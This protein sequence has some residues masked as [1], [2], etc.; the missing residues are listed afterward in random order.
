MTK[1]NARSICIALAAA[2]LLAATPALAGSIEF[3]PPFVFSGGFTAPAGLA[4]D[5]A[6]GRIVVADTGA[7]RVKW[8]TIASLVAGSPA[9]TELGFVAD[10][11]LPEALNEPQAVAVDGAGNVYVVDT[12]AGEVQLYRWNPGTS[13]YAYDPAFAA[14]TRNAVAGLN[15]RFPRDIAIGPANSVYL[16]DSG[17]ER[18]LRA[19]GANDD[20][21]EV[22]RA[23]TSWAN[24]Y[25]IDV[26]ADG[27][28]YLAD[29]D[30]HRIVR[31]P[32]AGGPG[33][34]FGA[35]GIGNVL[36]RN[37]R[38]VAV[39]G[40]GRMFVAD[41]NNHRVEILTSTGEHYRTLG[42]AP[43]YGSIQKIETDLYGRVYV[44]DSHASRLIAFL[45]SD[46]VAPF[47][48]YLRDYA[49]DPGTQPSDDAFV[50]SS[51]DLLVR[52][53]P[54]VDVA[55]VTSGL[56]LIAFEQP[57]FEMNNYVY[58]AVRNRGKQAITGVT[59]KVYWAD[60]GTTLAFPGQWKTHGFY[61]RYVDSS[62]NDPG[63]SIFIPHIAP[64]QVISGEEVD[65]VTVVGPLVWR[66]PAPESVLAADGKVH[67][68]A[69]LIHLDDPTETESG[70]DQV[71]LN[72]NVGLRRTEVTRGPF[73]IGDQDTLVVRA[74]FDGVAGSANETTVT[75]R[76]T[77]LN[78]WLDRVSYGLTTLK[79]AFLGP[80][81]LDHGPAH[82]QSAS[83]N[84]LVEMTTEVLSKLLATQ[85]DLLDGPTADAADDID[86][87]ILVVNDPA[88][89]TDWATTGHWPYDLAGKTRHLSTS[90]QGP[91]N[92]TP[93]YAHGLSHQFGLRDLYIHDTIDA[94]DL[95]NVASRWDNM[96]KPFEGAH[97]L[98][99][100]KQYATWVTSL[101]G[102][103]FYIARPPSSSPRLGQPPT[104]VSFQ[105]VLE[106]GQF[107]AIAVG[108]TEGVTTFEEETHFYWVEARDPALGSDLVPQKGVI[109]YYAH[110]LIPQGEAPVI[111]RD[112]T[113]GTDT[114]DDAAVPAG[115]QLAPG[116]TGITVT[117]EAEIAGDGG[118]LV[119][120]DYEPPVEDLDVH[121]RAGDP[122]WTSPDIWI[123]NQRDGDGY[124]AYDAAEH[125]SAGPTDEGPIA[126]EE[127][128]VYARI[129][130][131]GPAPAFDVEVVFSLSEPYHTVAGEADF[132]FKSLRIL[133]II[134]PG[135]HRDVFFTWVPDEDD[136]PHTCAYVEIRRA[137][138]DTN[139]HNNAAQQNLTVQP[140][141]TSS[142]YTAV[143]FNFQVTNEKDDRPALVYFRADNI[144]EPWTKAFAQ[145]KKLLGPSEKFLGSLMLKPN[146]DAPVCSDVAVYVTGW[147]P[148][149]DTLVQLGGTTVNVALRNN[150]TLTT[151]A[152]VGACN[153]KML[154]GA[155][156]AN[157]TEIILD[158]TNGPIAMASTKPF[159]R[160]AT[161]SVTGCTIPPRPNET[162]YI[163]YT[164]PAGNPVWR[165]VTTDE[166]GCYEDFYV[167][168]EGG[169]WEATAFY[170][171]S[172]CS[173]PATGVVSVFVPLPQTGDQDN[174]GLPDADEPQGNDDD[175][176]FPNHLDPD[177]DNDG[178]LD[179]AEPTGDADQDG[180][181]NSVDPDSDNDGIPDGSDPDPYTPQP[182]GGGTWKAGAF[183]GWL[184]LDRDLPINDTAVIGLRG[185]LHLSG[186]WWL[187]AEA[188]FGWTDDDF[189]VSG[190][191]LQA[192]VHLLRELTTG[193][194]ATPFVFGGAGLLKF[195]GFTTDDSSA[196]VDLG[197]GVDL[198]LRPWLDLRGDV[199]LILGSGAY[200]S[201]TT[202][203]L[204]ATIGLTI[205]P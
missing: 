186:P 195:D 141:R 63:N 74:D 119:R 133:P 62:T 37:P 178:V 152:G 159:D 175:D 2:F 202:R 131:T 187:E 185:A 138:N 189:G 46:S 79:P 205:R 129:H 25:G 11:S 150:T 72:N 3:G 120:I 61:R 58:V 134:P 130:N 90:V 4:V 110:K 199:R 60:P 93:Q 163:R 176:D 147:S 128:R 146:D 55:T 196:T 103:I 36:F 22:W 49:G 31:M 114:R 57:R 144:P 109:V 151:Q 40:S 5:D 172:D 100:S 83:N 158:T 124:H 24:P 94:P 48:A 68:F 197:V 180:L 84:L 19:D 123:D 77:E 53:D 98:V 27:K 194:T 145:P 44:I 111:V 32:A 171:G 106:D 73:P 137:T 104:P 43:L 82:Y 9:W 99:W 38:D 23:D 121:I 188:A 47:D 155:T 200:S 177:S 132:T 12:F 70:L 198:H 28:V 170:P 173:A 126:E 118:Y 135:Q 113:P 78:E 17:N 95:E 88:F 107:G 181:D 71:R 112:F 35:Y 136:E 14:T 165:E 10:R 81:P 67:L 153:R 45:G 108:L 101:G 161:I 92:T 169:P 80:V 117:V 26:G 143:N 76:I 190:R 154:G 21:W 192:D 166:F 54:D 42:V 191:V 168:V 122:A 174:D 115:E 7:H 183:I 91:S 66:P 56:E 29:T 139:E 89:T 75:T 140:S 85:P 149:G 203:N 201:G 51:P 182:G 30:N 50:L 39:D 184:D 164:D 97:P 64:R 13:T 8:A 33:T 6:N 193:T 125:T 142:P 34:S 96:A 148:R 41:M 65:G 16:L 204:E 20:S 1:T 15:I 18:I 69:R 156:G 102:K 127:N 179:G 160:C 105:S 86:R 87:V 167:V 157:G 162:I 59:L 52:H 116:G